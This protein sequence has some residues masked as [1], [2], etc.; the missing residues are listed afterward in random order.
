MEQ[1]NFHAYILDYV[2]YIV[3]SKKSTKKAKQ[4]KVNL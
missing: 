3:I 1:N 2:F 4:A